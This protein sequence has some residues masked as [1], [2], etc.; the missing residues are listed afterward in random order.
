M[1]QDY[2]LFLI[3]FNIIAV[4]LHILCDANTEGF[5]GVS[6]RRSMPY[7]SERLVNHLFYSV[8]GLV[9][10]KLGLFLQWF[11]E[12]NFSDIGSVR[13]TLLIFST[14]FAMLQLIVVSS[15]VRYLIFPE[16]IIGE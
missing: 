9:F 14:G 15:Q 7:L 4:A 6:G 16:E 3:S 13:I 11:I 8:V 2:L 10:W 1:N 5:F 12:D